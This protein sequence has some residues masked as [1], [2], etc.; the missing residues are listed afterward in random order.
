MPHPPATL[1]PASAPVARAPWIVAAV[2]WGL[3]PTLVFGLLAVYLAAK[4]GAWALGP[5]LMGYSVAR[6]LLLLA[7]ERLAPARQE[8][9]MT[10]RSFRR[11]LKFGGINLLTLVA[12]KKGTALL[13]ID[14]SRF[15]LGLLGGASVWLEVLV[16]LLV[17]EFFQ[18]G[19]HRIA[20]EGRGRL[21][22]FLWRVHAAHHLPQGVY[23]LMH[24][25]GHPINVLLVAAIN[26]PLVLLGASPG[27]LFFFNALVGVQGLVSHLNADVRVGP[28]NYLLVGTELHRYHHSADV[29]EA[30][31]FG[32]VTPF[33]DLVFGTF[34][35]RPGRLPA[36]LGV[37]QP[38]RYPLSEDV[39][40]VMALPFRG[41]R[42]NRKRTE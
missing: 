11:D 19:V 40:K 18:Y 8:W 26:L 21:G 35:Y 38:Q 36:K 30:C 1:S 41:P 13:A 22:G 27:A 28:L 15:N 2:R 39:W 25:V 10:W 23:V 20:H 33:W 12:V 42:R 24:G 34:V 9:A 29:S 3:Y 16:L 37:A 31:N 7:A 6:V 5:A 4:H 32:V 17:Y 14:A